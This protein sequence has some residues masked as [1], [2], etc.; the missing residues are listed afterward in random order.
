MNSGAYELRKTA[1]TMD[2]EID[3]E[4]YERLLTEAQDELAQFVLAD[5]TVAFATPAHIVTANKPA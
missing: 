3:D 4:G 1:E 2:D 5:G